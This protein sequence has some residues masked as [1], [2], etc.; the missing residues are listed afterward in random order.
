MLL[1]L[2]QFVKQSKFLSQLLADLC[3][4][5]A[6]MGPMCEATVVSSRHSSPTS[7][8]NCHSAFALL[9]KTFSSKGAAAFAS[10][11]GL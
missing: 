9:G 7:P 2:P 3:I 1:Q 10:V 8:T 6:T 11:R 4:S 5:R